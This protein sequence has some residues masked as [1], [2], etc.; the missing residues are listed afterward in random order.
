MLYLNRVEAYI[1]DHLRDP[2]LD[3]EKYK[4]VEISPL[5]EDKKS[6]GS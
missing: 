3:M 6:G 4:V 2:E 1:T 5:S